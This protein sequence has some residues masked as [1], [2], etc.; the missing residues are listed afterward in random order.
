MSPMRY[1][2]ELPP[3]R[4]ALVIGLYGALALTALLL[5]AGRGDAD[6]YRLDES[7]DA[8]RLLLSPVF[9]LLLGLAVVAL[10]RVAVNR[11]AWARE[12]HQ[13]FRNLLGPVTGREII[14][15]AAA[16]A[17]GEELM[18]RG[19]L[20]PWIGLWPQAILFALLHIGPGWRY[21]YW[22]AMALVLGVALGLLARLTG[23]LGG[24]I[25][26]HFTINFVNLRF[27]ARVELPPIA[28]PPL[29]AADA[30]P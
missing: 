8:W 23:D 24:V 15:L 9:G 14:I 27:I 19:A 6:I 26:A 17:I 4:G 10:S 7:A 25:V 20:E 2:T 16:S 30:E 3:S 13:S 1:R 5:S 18:F 21:L 28:A 11:T 22:T 12:L 29:T